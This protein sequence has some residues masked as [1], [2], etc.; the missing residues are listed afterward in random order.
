MDQKI[1][2]QCMLDLPIGNLK[3]G[4]LFVIADNALRAKRDFNLYGLADMVANRP[5]IGLLDYLEEHGLLDDLPETEE[6]L[7]EEWQ[8]LTIDQQHNRIFEPADGFPTVYALQHMAKYLPAA[9]KLLNHSQYLTIATHLDFNLVDDVPIHDYLINMVDE[10]RANKQHLVDIVIQ[11]NGAKVK[12]QTDQLRAKHGWFVTGVFD[13]HGTGPSYAYTKG[14][15]AQ[16][17][18]G[19]SM[20]AVIHGLSLNVL[21]SV[22]NAVAEKH[23]N[24][25]DIYKEFNDVFTGLAK[26]SA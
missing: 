6:Q 4:E 25:E 10:L 11:I 13:E 12:H 22:I 18:F 20:F 5:E 2:D 7:A 26:V 21:G 19:F 3:A 8:S 9:D 15:A 23:K 14:M 16:E 1:I 17:A 24:G